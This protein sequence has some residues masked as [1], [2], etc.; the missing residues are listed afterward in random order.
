MTTVASPF[1]GST[2]TRP[3]LPT[4]GWRVLIAVAA[5]AGAFLLVR[6]IAHAAATPGIDFVHVWRAGHQLLGGGGSYADPLFTYP[7]SAALLLAPFGAFAYGTA[8]GLMLAF[9][10]AG[11]ASAAWLMLRMLGKH[12]EWRWLALATLFLG[13]SD[14]TGSTWA[15]GN[16][17]GGLVLLE[18]L[19]IDAMRRDRWRRAAVLIGISLALKPVLLPIVVVF[20]ARRKW[21][22]LAISLT[23]P[24]SLSLVGW[25]VIPDAHRFV[26]VV[27]PFLMQGAQLTFNDSLVGVGYMLGLGGF[28]VAVMRA[29]VA[30]LAVLALVPP[31]R[32]SRKSPTSDFLYVEIGVALAATFLVSPMSETYYTL[33]L[34]PSVAWMLATRRRL[35]GVLVTII[36]VCFT[37]LRLAGL[38]GPVPHSTLLAIRPSVGWLALLVCLASTSFRLP[39]TTRKQT[40]RG[41]SAQLARPAL[42]QPS[43]RTEIPALVRQ[44]HRP[45][46]VRY[47]R[48][49]LGTGRDSR[50]PQAAAD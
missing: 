32:K 11:I 18:V 17:N 35:V 46:A 16:I 27:V 7:P 42:T 24:T 43:G 15:N 13:A 49:L 2:G 12:R 20:F 36:I 28:T 45:A 8:K 14:A 41:P 9:N 1:P 39:R 6:Q 22:A 37:T 4:W 33:Y 44:S 29:V 50:G 30:G 21:A 23:I 10:V 25:V 31:V 48:S 34:L 5:A 26:T 3:G 38:P 40:P 19:A 47:P